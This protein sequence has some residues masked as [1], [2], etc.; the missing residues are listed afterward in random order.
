MTEDLLEYYKEEISALREEGESFAH[1]FPDVAKKINFSRSESSDPQMERLLESVAFLAARIRVQNDF[2]MG[3]VAKILLE[4]IYRDAIE[5]IPALGMIQFVISDDS[6]QSFG[7]TKI[8]R[9]ENILIKNSVGD[10]DYTFMTTCDS[11]IIPANIE[12]IECVDGEDIGITEGKYIH[13]KLGWI[14]D[15]SVSKKSKLRLFL[16]GPNRYAIWDRM[17]CAESDVYLYENEQKLGVAGK[18]SPVGFSNDES[19]F[20][21]SN[22]YPGYRALMEYLVFSEKFVGV[23]VNIN[24]DYEEFLD[25]Y[26][27]IGESVVKFNKADFLINTVPIVNFYYTSSEPMFFDQRV[28][29]QM[30]VPNSGSYGSEHICRIQEVHKIGRSGHGTEFIPSYFDSN[31]HSLSDA[32]QIYWKEKKRKNKIGIENTYISFLNIDFTKPQITSDDVFYARLLCN[33]TD[34][35]KK[36]DEFS[37]ITIERAMPISEIKLVQNLSSE[38]NMSMEGDNIWKLVTMLSLNSLSLRGT[39]DLVNIKKIMDFFIDLLKIENA[40]ENI[41]DAVKSINIRNTVKHASKEVWRGFVHGYTADVLIDPRKCKSAV[42][43][44]AVIGKLLSNFVHIDAFIEVNLIY[45]GGVTKTW[46]FSE[47]MIPWM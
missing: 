40:K 45:N 39:N 34:V 32:D 47:G 35:A 11:E 37:E 7:I 41:S 9:G 44:S 26:I 43:L 5:C 27:P 14:G 17:M 24:S 21:E 22:A 4:C 12:S 42:M 33:N 19:I 46:N 28:T 30:L 31:K 1:R 38:I 20:A 25:V 36:L 23:D 10:A 16:T 15:S 18:V 13:I 8:P 3:D 29:E 6:A 2:L